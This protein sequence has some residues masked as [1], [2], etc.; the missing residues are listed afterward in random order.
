LTEAVKLNPN[1][2]EARLTVAE[3][4][5]GTGAVDL[6]LEEAREVLKR[7]PNRFRPVSS[8]EMFIFLKRISQSDE[9]YEEVIQ[10]APNNA[11]GYFHLGRVL[12]AQ[13]KEKEALP[14][15]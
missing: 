7:D 4:H 13:K 10:I 14:P 9:I 1:W 3:L 12:L 5:L 15:V 11:I 8:L 2:I 6:A